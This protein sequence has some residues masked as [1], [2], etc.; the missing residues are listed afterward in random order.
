MKLTLDDLRQL[1]QDDPLRGYR[2]RF[3]LPRDTDG[4]DQLY[5]CGNSLGLQPR[6]AAEAVNEVLDAWRQ[7]AVAGHFDG[8][9][10]WMSYQDSLRE[11]LARLAGA[12]PAEVVV[13]NTLTVNLHLLL[14]S[15]FRP[16]G[17]RN[18]IVIERQPFPSDRYAA[19]SQLRLNGLDPAECLVELG[20]DSDERTI[21]ESEIEA[22]LAREG[23]RVAL[24]LWPGVHYASGQRFDIRRITAAAHAAGALA[25]FDL[26]HAIG[27]VP[28][29]L[30]L[31]GPDFAAWCTYKYLNAGPGAIAAAFIHERH[32]GRPDL[33]AL[34]GWWG[35]DP[36]V[37]FLMGPEFQPA[38]G[39]DAWQLSTPP[40]LSMAPLRAAL[41]LFDQAGMDRLRRKSVDLTGALERLI[42]QHAADL[43]EILTP[44]EPERR[45][46]QLSLRV[47]SDRAAGRRL[48]EALLACGV[49]GDWREPDI[50][51]V[52]PVPLYNRFEDCWEFVG[53]ARRCAAATGV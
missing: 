34:Q 14:L 3:L 50:I 40:I 19:A 1:D 33:P 35:A 13:M 5:L 44:A 17:R 26:A 42:Q 49:T 2:A 36:A 29:Q 27:N 4:A 51:R 45:G 32:L 9:H 16:R 7:R 39:A 24:V 47:K 53:R 30:H 21:D 15:F 48:F 18:R 6:N 25:G 38:A 28:L 11:P 31:D 52:A 20:R 46:C 12:R 22:Y 43:F 8:D 37:R 10:P 23:E 41:E